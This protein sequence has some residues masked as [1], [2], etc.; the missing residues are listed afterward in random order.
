MDHFYSERPQVAQRFENCDVAIKMLP[1][2]ASD[3][4]RSEFMNEIALVSV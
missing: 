4:S 2:Y 1:K 3:A